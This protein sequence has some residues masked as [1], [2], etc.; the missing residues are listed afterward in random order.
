MNFERELLLD[1][2]MAGGPLGRV[3]AVLRTLR[4]MASGEPNVLNVEPASDSNLWITRGAGGDIGEGLFAM[5]GDKFLNRRDFA[6]RSAWEHAIREAAGG[7]LP[8]AEAWIPARLSDGV[9]ELTLGY[10]VFERSTL[11]ETL[12]DEAVRSVLG[13]VL[14]GVRQHQLESYEYIG[15]EKIREELARLDLI[16]SDV[17]SEERLFDVLY[18]DLSQVLL[19][20][21][22]CIAALQVERWLS[23]GKAGTTPPVH[24]ALRH[25]W[26]GCDALPEETRIQVLDALWKEVTGNAA[27][28]RVPVPEC[29]SIELQ[30]DH[31]IV[32]ALGRTGVRASC[33]IQSLREPTLVDPEDGYPF[34]AALIFHEPGHRLLPAERSALLTYLRA[35]RQLVSLRDKAHFAVSEE[36]MSKRLTGLDSPQAVAQHVV[37]FVSDHFHATEVAVLERR[38]NFLSLLAQTGVSILDVPPLY[39]PGDHGLVCAVAREGKLQYNPDALADPR[40]LPVVPTTRTQLT[41][42]LVWRNEVIG[43]MVVGLGVLD[44]LTVHDMDSIELIATQCAESINAIRRQADS[45]ALFHMLRDNLPLAVDDVATIADELSGVEGEVP[46]GQAAALRA[47]A[48]LLQQCLAFIREYDEARVE[49]ETEFD[50][51]EVSKECLRR[52]L[53]QPFHDNGRIDIEIRPPAEAIRVRSDQRAVMLALQHLVLNGLEAIET[54]LQEQPD[55]DPLLRLTLEFERKSDSIASIKD[56]LPFGVIHV[57]DQGVG[58][59]INEQDRIGTLFYSTKPDRKHLGG[60]ISIAKRAADGFAGRITFE[61]EEGRGSRFS[62]WIPISPW[63]FL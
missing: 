41:L 4:R 61:S 15:L 48:E 23:L 40:Y 20:E 52:E 29:R 50:I 9:G 44:G 35:A 17:P 51:Y 27:R 13:S 38:G 55:E 37:E 63:R 14:I 39:I 32:A 24:E 53:F 47:T 60:G 43:S 7:Q 59:P 46:S 25:A 42:P 45:R 30:A 56:E 57:A 8:P 31:P 22:A 49:G 34:L 58:I 36:E 19:V 2:T 33:L 12:Q 16:G 3:E 26:F 10:C 5:I 11:A 62:L 28:L 21:A 54:R 6:D 18:A 1:L